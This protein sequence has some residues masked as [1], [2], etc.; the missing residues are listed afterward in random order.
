VNAASASAG[1]T[2][3]ALA[4]LDDRVGDRRVTR[5]IKHFL[6]T[7]MR[8]ALLLPLA[9]LTTAC[10]GAFGTGP[11]SRAEVPVELR[12]D[13]TGLAAGGSRVPTATAAPG[14]IT[15]KG[16][17]VAG[18][19]CQDL[20]AVAGRNERGELVLAITAV[21][22]NVICVAAL[23]GFTYTATVRDLAPGTYHLVVV[24]ATE[25]TGRPRYEDR[26]LETS[27]VVR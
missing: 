2:W 25:V 27:V 24:H 6:E 1:V 20:N 11:G 22:Q 12:I 17:L 16:Q 8:L 7:T 13:S 4:G 5:P 26:V 15:V 3:P 18:N 9:L 14:Q 19:P 10:S 21:A 23:G